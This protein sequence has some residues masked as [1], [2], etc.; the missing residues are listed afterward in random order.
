[1]KQEDFTKIV[2]NQFDKCREILIVKAAEYDRNDN[3]FHNF[4]IG[5]AS[6]T[7]GETREEVIWG[8]ARKHFISIQD[9]RTDLRRNILASREKIEEKYTDFINYILLEK[10]SLL[11]RHIQNDVALARH[12]LHQARLKEAEAKLPIVGKIETSE[13]C[14]DC[15]ELCPDYSRNED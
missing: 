2:E 8:M 15:D 14:Q 13:P 10:A 4:E 3:R 12:N 6:S 7:I 5:A 9:I 1:M 11:D